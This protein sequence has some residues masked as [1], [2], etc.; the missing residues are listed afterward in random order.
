MKE[1]LFTRE[2]KKSVDE[3][4]KLELGEPE[5][6]SVKGKTGRRTEQQMKIRQ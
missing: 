3:I 4:G 2:Y 1:K 5:S 6:R